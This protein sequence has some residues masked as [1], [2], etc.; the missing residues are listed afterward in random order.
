VPVQAQTVWRRPEE[1]APSPVWEEAGGGQTEDWQECRRTGWWCLW[2]KHGREGDVAED[3][4]RAAS[5]WAL[6]GRPVRSM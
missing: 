5:M 6:D 1:A 3:Q 4:R 2:R